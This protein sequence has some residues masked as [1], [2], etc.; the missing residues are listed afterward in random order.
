MATILVADVLVGSFFWSNQ[1]CGYC[2]PAAM[3]VRGKLI[4]LECWLHKT[5]DYCAGCTKLVTF[6]M[7]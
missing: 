6:D 7:Y 2:V 1:T 4:A 5:C 3:L